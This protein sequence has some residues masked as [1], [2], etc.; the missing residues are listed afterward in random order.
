MSLHGMLRTSEPQLIAYTSPFGSR[1]GKFATVTS[2]SLPLGPLEECDFRTGSRV[3]AMR[4][5]QAEAYVS[6]M[7]DSGA[8]GG[9]GGSSTDDSV[10]AGGI[11]P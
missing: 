5:E 11:T 9:T 2:E 4:T 8:T 7:D 10:A 3:L 6:G 1:A